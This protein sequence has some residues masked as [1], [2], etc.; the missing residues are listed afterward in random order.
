MIDHLYAVRSIS[1]EVALEQLPRL[2]LAGGGAGSTERL[3]RAQ[4]EVPRG[5]NLPRVIH[6]THPG[7]E[8]RET[9]ATRRGPRRAPFLRSL[10][11]W[12]H[13]N[14]VKR[15]SGR[16]IRRVGMEQLSEV[17]RRRSGPGKSELSGMAAQHNVFRR[18]F[19]LIRNPRMSGA[20][21][22][23]AWWPRACC[24]KSSIQPEIG[25]KLQSIIGSVPNFV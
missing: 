9:W 13:R 2:G 6:R 21:G 4:A 12:M 7:L 25:L 20:P 8:H 22:R 1:A 14:P 11:W 18:V 16:K 10:G 23:V 19:P 17:C 24:K 3:E 5:D 15:L